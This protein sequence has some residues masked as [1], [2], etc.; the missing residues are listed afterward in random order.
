MVA[1]PELVKEILNNR[2]GAYPNADG[3]AFVKKL[4]GDG[5]VTTEGDKRVK[6]R[7]LANFAFKGDS[8]KVSSNCYCYYCNYFYFSS[9]GR[10]KLFI[11]VKLK[12]F[13][14]LMH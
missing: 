4:L 12:R 1:E 14:V 2:D 7:K 8:L 9:Y 6:L 5:L 10:N 11:A 13:I 3:T